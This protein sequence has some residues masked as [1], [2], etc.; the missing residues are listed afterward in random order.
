MK[1][2]QFK[3]FLS[4]N[5]FQS[6]DILL[7]KLGLLNI[8]SLS[9]SDLIFLVKKEPTILK[10][11]LLQIDLLFSSQAESLT[12]I[13]PQS[14]YTSF[15]RKLNLL[16]W[17]ILEDSSN[18]FSTIGPN[19]NIDDVHILYR[20]L[21]SH[22]GSDLVKKISL[23]STG[24]LTRTLIADSESSWLDVPVWKNKVTKWL[25]NFWPDQGSLL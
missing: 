17:G 2:K 1:V 12:S 5:G 10:F 19:F 21:F 7:Y 11:Y 23:R 18:K 6:N 24:F 20:D 13:I 22:I 9:I 3:Y 25:S 4:E 15:I 8:N 14:T 16:K